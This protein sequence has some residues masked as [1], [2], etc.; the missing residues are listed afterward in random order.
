MRRIGLVVGTLVLIGCAGASGTTATGGDGS[1]AP[2]ETVAVPNVVHER[3]AQARSRIR[4][5][6]LRMRT[7]TLSNLCAGFAGGGR[8]LLQDP[9]GRKRVPGDSLVK[10]QTSCHA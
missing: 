4:E 5:R 7:T 2:K 9:E 6:G 1:T 10:V 8:I 3:W